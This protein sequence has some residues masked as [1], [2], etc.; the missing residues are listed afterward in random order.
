MPDDIYRTIINDDKN[1]FYENLSEYLSVL[2]NPTR[3]RILKLVE[4][5]PK[6]IREI[7]NEIETSSENTKKHLDKLLKIGII[8]KEAGMGKPTSKGI[9]AV[10]KYSAIPGGLELIARNIGNFCNMEIKNPEMADRLLEIRKMVDKEMSADMPVLVI[11]GGDD[12]GKV[13][14]IKK[15][16][17]RIGRYDPS[18]KGLFDEEYDIVL[19]DEYRAVTRVSKPHAVIFKENNDWRIL[20]TESSGGTF[21]NNKDIGKSHR[22][23]LSDGDMIDLGKGEGSAS[24]IFHLKN[25]KNPE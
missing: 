10:W 22:I 19:N 5:N 13:F 24:F 3:L 1:G 8:K 15:D 9:H 16:K 2:G 25:S 7:S 20:D 21:L 6:D 18:A 11:L 23:S 17:V 12:D 14:L 4:N